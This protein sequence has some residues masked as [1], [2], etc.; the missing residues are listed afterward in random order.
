MCEFFISYFISL[1]IP[2]FKGFSEKEWSKEGSDIC[3]IYVDIAEIYL[4]TYDIS[5]MYRDIAEIHHMYRDIAE[6]SEL[7]HIINFENTL[8]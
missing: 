3:Q 2:Y 4:E 5:H 6:I 1:Y 8:E 7:Y